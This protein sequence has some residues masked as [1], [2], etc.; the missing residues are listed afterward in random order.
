MYGNDAEFWDGTYGAIWKDMTLYVGDDRYSLL[1]DTSDWHVAKSTAIERQDSDG[2]GVEFQFQEEWDSVYAQVFT[3][4][5]TG[6]NVEF[7]DL[8]QLNF[9][10]KLV[11][12]WPDHGV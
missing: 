12:G 8:T 5:H 11:G 4:K 2:L 10:V 9:D 6:A 1:D 3:S 7:S